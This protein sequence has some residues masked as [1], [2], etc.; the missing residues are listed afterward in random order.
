M[1]L[2][3]G[4]KIREGNFIKSSEANINPTLDNDKVPRLENNG[5]LD[6]SFMGGFGDGSDGD[7]VM[8]G[9]NTYAAFTTKSGNIYTLTRSVLANNLTIGGSATLRTDGFFIFVKNKIDGS[10][11]IEWGVPNNGGSGSYSGG[12]GASPAGPGGAQSGTGP[13][14]ST[15]GLAGGVGGGTSSTAGNGPGVGADTKTECIG[16]NTNAGQQGGNG[17]SVAGSAGG[18]A[19]TRTAPFTP[20]GI[21]RSLLTMLM[22]KKS[23]NTLATI[24][25][26]PAAPGGG[27]GRDGSSSVC[28]GPGGGGAA[29]GGLVVIFARIWAGSFTIRSVGGVG[30]AGLAGQGVNTGGGAGGNGGN[31]GN[32]IV[33]FA[34]KLWTGVFNLA[35]GAGGN[36]GAS[37]GGGGDTAGANGLAGVAGT[38]YEIN[39]GNLV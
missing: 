14:K 15:A 31:G 27:G 24:T 35:G 30:G 37:G 29:S 3:A 19:G 34:R 10:G 23:D 22:D 1:T 36:G 39:A 12:S 28:S 26:Q 33:I 7:V 17:N 18:A 4:E 5:A 25:N 21:F 20:F 6:A 38:S 11:I 9:T 2:R 8:D 13:L 32:A 16:S